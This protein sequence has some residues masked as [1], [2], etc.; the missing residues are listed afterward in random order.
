MAFGPTKICNM[1]LRKVGANPISDYDN[2]TS[3]HAQDC[4]LYFPLVLDT[5]LRAYDWNCA[6]ARRQ[7]LAEDAE[8]VDFGYRY[9][10]VLPTDPWCLKVRQREDADSEF[11]IE[12]RR[13]LC[14]D[15]A[16]NI[17]Y[18]KRITDFTE[19]DPL[20]TEVLVYSLAI[21]LAPAI[22]QNAQLPKDCVAFMREVWLPMA[23]NANGAESRTEYTEQQTK[24]RVIDRNSYLP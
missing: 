24:V 6:T 20:L 10:F 19:L 8:E 13:L 7:Y 18:T 17:I 21:E 5:V 1:S 4:R 11:R 9:Q 3:S 14:D 2:D 22:K 15:E 16:I 23:L 12:G